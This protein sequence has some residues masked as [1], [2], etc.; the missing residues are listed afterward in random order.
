[1]K[2]IITIFIIV[3]LIAAGVYF[4][5][6]RKVSLKADITGIETP[7]IN[8]PFESGVNDLE[9][10]N[11]DLGASL[12]SNLFPNIS[13]GMQFGSVGEIGL[14]SV[15]G[16]MSAEGLPP[17]GWEPDEATCSQFNLAPSCSFVPSEYRDLCQQCKDK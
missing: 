2:K 11:F 8:M 16:E 3:L 10:N 5:F 1:M 6:F 15:S 13:A 17:A 12:P 9:L 7:S 4:G 14:P